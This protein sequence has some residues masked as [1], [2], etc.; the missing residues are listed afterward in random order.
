MRTSIKFLFTLS[1]LFAMILTGLPL[2]PDGP[3]QT[4]AA[5]TRLA[6]EDLDI[7]DEK[8]VIDRVSQEYEIIRI[9]SNATLEI[10][11]AVLKAKKIICS[12]NTVNS[13]LIMQ[14]VSGVQ[15][16]LSIT[17]GIVN[18][19]AT[20]IELRGAKI[21]VLNGSTIIPPGDTGKPSELALTSRQYDLV[22]NNTELVARGNDGGDGDQKKFGGP[23]GASYIF[24]GTAGGKKVDISGTRIQ[25]QGGQGGDSYT[26]GINAGIGGDANLRIDGENVNIRNS[27]ITL[28]GG[29][30]GSHGATS[31]GGEGGQTEIRVESNRDLL[32]HSTDMDPTDGVDTTLQQTYASRVILRSKSGRVLWDHQKTDDEKMETLSHV[33]SDVFQIDGASG[34]EL[35]QVDTGDEP[36]DTLGTSVLKLYWWAKILVQ[37][38]VN[39]DPMEGAKIQW[40]IEP[41]PERLP[42]DVDLFTDEEGRLNIEVVARQNLDWHRY[43]FWAVI[44]G[45][46]TGN[47]DQ[48]RFDK[49]SN[50]DI[51]IKITRIF[52][53]VK[54]PAQNEIVGGNN[55]R[56]YGTAQPGN[57]LNEMQN[58]NLYI[59]G[60][61]IGNAT[62]ISS[63]Q[64]Q[65]YSQWEI[66][67]DTTTVPDG[68]HVLSAV[69]FDSAYQVKLDKV[70]D[71]EQ[72]SVNHRP[73]LHSLIVLD[74]EG[75]K[76]AL[77]EEKIELH[78]DQDNPVLTFKVDAYDRDVLSEYLQIG[79]GKKIIKATMDI[80]Y[81][82]TGAVIYNDKVVL[83]DD[84]EKSNLSGGF[85]FSFQINTETKPGTDDPYDEG[86]YRLEF[87]IED[88]G[89]LMSLGNVD[90]YVLFE[91]KFDFY[92]FIELY[93][94]PGA[95]SNKEIRSGADPEAIEESFKVSS[96][97]GDENDA[98]GSH[99]Y[100]AVFNLSDCSDRDDPLWS[101]DPSLD[102]SWSNLRYTVI[103]IDDQKGDRNEVLNGVKASGFTHTFDLRGN[104]KNED[105]LF[106]VIIQA[107]DQEDLQSE[108]RWKVRIN[109]VPP[110]EPYVIPV[111]GIIPYGD[112]FYG[113]FVLFVIILLGYVVAL[114]IVQ[115]QNKTERGKKMTM[116]EKRKKEE[117]AKKGSSAIEEEFHMG[118]K[119]SR[120]YLEATGAGKGKEEFAK[121]LEAAQKKEEL[122]APEK[123]ELPPAQ[124][125]PTTAQPPQQAPPAPPQQQGSVPRQAA[126]PTPV[127]P[128]Q[129]APPSPP[130]SHP[131]PA[132]AQ[133]PPVQQQAAPRPPVQL[134][135]R[136]PVQQQAAPQGAPAA[137]APQIRPQAPQQAQPR[138]PA[139]APPPAPPAQRPPVRPPQQQ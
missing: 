99:T 126:P 16:L 101:D 46:A 22:I 61:I 129:Q 74:T 60:N 108:M 14:E 56:I 127:Q 30:G 27:V 62:D 89:G 42:K 119:D 13:T 117:E 11:G 28:L 112:L 38:S 1:I 64:S 6:G 57:P 84:I 23:G 137:P 29:G 51:P 118:R 98:P 72:T 88:D 78:V 94:E 125:P 105:V 138:P 66:F 76:E 91:L 103:I 3:V 132:P 75:E 110:E 4:E 114:G 81:T 96:R 24:L 50:L 15:A 69:A 41:E 45:G 135:Q 53:D 111:V 134:P 17:E 39:N 35:H 25:G 115:R 109:Y 71:V 128:P 93:I 139:A 102:R 73:E 113:F 133:R 82:S 68:L 2:F 122:P 21:S 48:F 67:W 18:V 90:N 124:T 92:P 87:Y 54:K 32:I 131:S 59:D 130:A 104:P 40:T 55:Y 10:R 31:V 79:E 43:T 33:D 85:E 121:E 86:E 52:L 65:P 107:V 100:K 120:A 97:M 26:A 5:P 9:R 70:I 63:V 106:T 37:D 19:K 47:S 34:A 83:E 44:T 58:I 80:I 12:E 116:L 36:P 7:E 77:P 95:H 49:N 123:K 8:V 136:P 20:K